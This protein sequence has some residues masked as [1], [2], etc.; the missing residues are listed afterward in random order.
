MRPQETVDQK[1]SKAAIQ[2]FLFES[3]DQAFRNNVD[4]MTRID[5]DLSITCGVIGKYIDATGGRRST[6][7]LFRLMDVATRRLVDVSP[8]HTAAQTA[9][10]IQIFK[11]VDNI[12]QVQSH[13]P[14]NDQE[15]SAFDSHAFEMFTVLGLTRRDLLQHP[16]FPWSLPVDVAIRR[17]EELM[18]GYFLQR[19]EIL[20]QAPKDIVRKAIRFHAQ[21]GRL[22]TEIL[23]HEYDLIARHHVR[24][25]S[26][27]LWNIISMVPD[28]HAPSARS[29]VFWALEA[30]S[31]RDIEQNDLTR[32]WRVARHKWDTLSEKDK[33]EFITLGFLY[34]F[35]SVYEHQAEEHIEP[36]HEMDQML[37]SIIQNTSPERIAEFTKGYIEL[38]DEGHNIPLG[39]IATWFPQIGSAVENHR[40]QTAKQPFHRLKTIFRRK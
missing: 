36:N 35:A 9:R 34:S 10:D 38:V 19:M 29:V 39:M 12:L 7:I 28:G 4:D 15:Q 20:R 21:H 6:P 16:D 25:T 30:A 31:Y 22:I 5:P 33:G 27:D 2:Y 37:Q 24:S 1:N 23:G 14:Q 13:T 11:R 17:K 40:A 32:V 3:G 18:S 8:T 26:A